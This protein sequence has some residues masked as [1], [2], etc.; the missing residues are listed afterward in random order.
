MRKKAEKAQ[1]PRQNASI[2]PRLLRI[3][4]PQRPCDSNY[5]LHVEAGGSPL[6]CFTASNVRPRSEPRPGGLQ[7]TEDVQRP[8]IIMWV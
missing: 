2:F 7:S 4:A 1:E 8:V 3:K 6:R 5:N